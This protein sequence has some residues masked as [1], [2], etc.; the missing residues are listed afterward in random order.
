MR[1]PDVDSARTRG[2]RRRSR[3]LIQGM[4]TN[5][6]NVNGRTTSRNAEPEIS[7]TTENERPRSEVNVMSPNPRVVI[8]V[9]VQ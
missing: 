8:V 5:W 1:C 6:M 2:A 3:S 9:I 4:K 7:T